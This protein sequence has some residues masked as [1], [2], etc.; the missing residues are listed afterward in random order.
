MPPEK[1]SIIDALVSTGNAVS[2]SE[3]RRAV[4]L[5]SVQI[6]GEEVRDIAALLEDGDAVQRIDRASETITVRYA[7]EWRNR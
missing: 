3:A 7:R 6:N 4:A 5:G 2:R 1:I